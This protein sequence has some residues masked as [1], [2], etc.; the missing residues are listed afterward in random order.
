[1]KQRFF[2]IIGAVAALIG[3][4]SFN[5]ASVVKPVNN[6]GKDIVSMAKHKGIAG[7]K[8]SPVHGASDRNPYKH[9]WGIKNQRQYRKWMR[10]CPQMRR[11]KKCRV[12]SK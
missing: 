2:K 3:L 5:T 11:S 7:Q 1:M 12:K 10:Q 8:L 4:S 6:T 9:N